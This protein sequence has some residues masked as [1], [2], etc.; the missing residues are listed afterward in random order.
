MDSKWMK[1]AILFQPGFKAIFFENIDKK[2]N[3][4]LEPENE[5][6]RGTNFS[7]FLVKKILN[8]QNHS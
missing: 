4:S 6:G 2:L 1:R 3:I 5:K 8:Y 7:N